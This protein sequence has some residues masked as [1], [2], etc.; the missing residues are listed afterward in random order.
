MLLGSIVFRVLRFGKEKD[1][2]FYIY[3]F[4]LLLFIV[5][6]IIADLRIKFILKFFSFLAPWIGK[7]SFM[8]F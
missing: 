4:Y 3:T 7:G 6:I 8:I 1:P 2:F 5:M